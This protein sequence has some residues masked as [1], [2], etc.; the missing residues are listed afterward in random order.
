M[1]ATIYT[2]T[3]LW[4][5]FNDSL[6]LKD[7]TIKTLNVNDAELN[8][9]Y[10]SGR[11]TELNRVRIYGIFAKQKTPTNST[12]V[13]LPD[14]SCGV[15][16]EIVM[17]YY[18][19]GYNVL[20]VDIRGEHNG[21]ADFT[22]YPKDVEYAN[23]SKSNRS[24]YYADVTAKQTCWYE[25]TSVARYAVSF[26]KNKI[27]NAKIGVLGIKNSANVLWQL[28]SMD[29]RVDSAIFL[30]GAGW[31]AYKDFYKLEG[32]VFETNEE[33]RRFL[34]GVDAQA[35]AQFVECPTLF[36][37]STNNDNFD[38]DRAHDTINRIKNQEDCYYCFLTNFK[39][40]LDFHALENTKI[41]LD[42]Y[43]NNSNTTLGH[44]YIEAET[45]DDTVVLT[46]S[47]DNF[48]NIKSI[49][50]FLSYD[51]VSPKDRVWYNINNYVKNK[52]NTYTFTQSIY[53]D[54]KTIIAFAI[55]KYTNGFTIST[56]RLYKTV[57]LSSYSH[58]PS[59]L[60]N[61]SRFFSNYI[62]DDI[63]ETLIGDVFVTKRLFQLKKGPN[64]IM[65]L[66]T[67][68]ALTFYGVRKI[69]PNLKDEPFI[70][71]DVYTQNSN[72]ITF[73]VKDSNND[74]FYYVTNVNGGE[75]WEHLQISLE[76]FKDSNNL[77]LTNFKDLLFIKISSLG[78][79]TINNFLLI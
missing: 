29:K 2:P 52:D 23:F 49:Y 58:V 4:S 21:E 42:K 53:G 8:Y 77:P 67:N 1:D 17:Y 20:T 50:T 62:I 55:I 65:G 48:K 61:T 66:S 69:A 7:V 74:E 39:D 26:I 70:K 68:Y 64:D 51:D 13:I 9:V 45:E 36:I 75:H 25:W 47:A 16:A 34:A 6:P 73:T 35:Y 10:F 72:T 59:V 31:L 46:V 43:L 71:I 18:N 56:N 19:L 33:R 30:F 40:V 27:P 57:N 28:C 14:C 22:K 44:A 15:D 41:F 32:T 60:L 37:S 78:E 12:I 5:G 54:C 79:F 24:F 11:Q 76:D 3:T 38:S 63:D